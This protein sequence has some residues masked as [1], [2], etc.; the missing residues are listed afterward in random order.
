MLLRNW[1]CEVFVSSIFETS[2]TNNDWSA[3]SFFDYAG[4]C[5]SCFLVGGGSVLMGVGRI[6]RDVITFLEA[7]DDIIVW[8][9]IVIVK[10]KD[11]LTEKCVDVICM[12]MID[13]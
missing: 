6:K 10:H 3:T 1:R 7:V 8:V 9:I 13:L 12:M 11:V 2:S 4:E 5:F